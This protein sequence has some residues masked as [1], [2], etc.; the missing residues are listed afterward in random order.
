MQNNP[1]DHA[2]RVLAETDPARRYHAAKAA[3][4]AA[5]APYERVADEAVEDLI[6][7]HGGNVAA[8]ARELGLTRQALYMRDKREKTGGGAGAAAAEQV[9][10][11]RHFNSPQEAEDALRDWALDQQEVTDQLDVLLLGAL[12]AGADPVT[13]SELSGVPL[14]TL[15]RIRPGGN[16]TVSRLNEYGPEIEDFARAVHARAA[17]LR[18]AAA[19]K[20]EHRSASIWQHAARAIVTNVAPYALMPDPGIHVEDFDT[21]EE[22]AEALSTREPSEEEKA[23][24]EREPS[25][26]AVLSHDG[27]LAATYLVFRREAARERLPFEETPEEIAAGEAVQAAF[28]ELADAILHLRTTGQVPPALL[29]AS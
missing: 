18:A 4:E 26:L 22:F 27:Y 8:A 28:G 6:A 24:D 9:Q 12:A 5:A 29:E 13:I 23:E 14:A 15:R 19:T 20:A 1:L 16:I 2:A 17:A 25:R 7:Q 3:A 11:A 10:P 21:A